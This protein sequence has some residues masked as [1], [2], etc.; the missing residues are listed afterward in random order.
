MVTFSSTYILTQQQTRARA[1]CPTRNL[2]LESK[3]RAVT[4]WSLASARTCTKESGGGGRTIIKL[5][6][7]RH[8]RATRGS[9]GCPRQWKR[10][11]LLFGGGRWHRDWN[12][13]SD[14][15]DML[16]V[17]PANARH[18]VHRPVKRPGLTPTNGSRKR[19][20]NKAKNGYPHT[21]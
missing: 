6:R 20:V 16:A 4:R 15:L 17:H 10:R 7:R 8:A 18:H 5:R 2:T 9:C 12:G 19:K 11:N 21:H 14:V 1:Y 13:H 3:Q